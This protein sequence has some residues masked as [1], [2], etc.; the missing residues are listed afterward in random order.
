MI[1]NMS[2]AVELVHRYGNVGRTAEELIKAPPTESQL[3]MA[4]D[5]CHRDV[6]DAERIIRNYHKMEGTS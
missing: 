5:R 1:S 2:Q 4:I 3:E 6:N